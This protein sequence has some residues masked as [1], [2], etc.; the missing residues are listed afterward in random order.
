MKGWMIMRMIYAT[1]NAQYNCLDVNFYEG[2]ILPIDCN[3]AE[4]GLNTHQTYN[5]HSMH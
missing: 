5:A 3:K 4:E 1:Y 2:Y